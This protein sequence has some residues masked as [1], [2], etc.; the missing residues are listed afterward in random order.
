MSFF[1][2]NL[3]GRIDDMNTGWKGRACGR[4]TPPLAAHLEGGKGS[5]A[6]SSTSSIVPIRWRNSPRFSA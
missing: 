4:N 2:K 1:A 3:D 6:R 5:R